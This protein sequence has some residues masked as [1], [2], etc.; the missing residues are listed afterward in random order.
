MTAVRR[1]KNDKKQT[2]C[3]IRKCNIGTL[4]EYIRREQGLCQ[5][6]HNQDDGSMER[7]ALL[8]EILGEWKCVQT[9]R[10]KM[11]HC[12]SEQLTCKIYLYGSMIK[13]QDLLAR[14]IFLW[15]LSLLQETKR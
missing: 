13:E 6:F 12:S 8:W 1:M 10:E 4:T 14:Q 15:L 9:R 3:I 11:E 2:T 7:M 5:F